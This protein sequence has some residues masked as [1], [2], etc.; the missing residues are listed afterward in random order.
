METICT[1]QRKPD[2]PIIKDSV[3]SRLSGEVIG[4]LKA[5]GFVEEQDFGLRQIQKLQCST[6]VIYVDGIHPTKQVVIA[7]H[8]IGMD[9]EYGVSYKG[10]APAGEEKVIKRRKIESLRY[11]ISSGTDPVLT[12]GSQ[13]KYLAD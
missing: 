5:K 10:D 4:H 8:S 6:K 7:F 2:D 9:I 13:E 3:M 12:D 11:N 1:S